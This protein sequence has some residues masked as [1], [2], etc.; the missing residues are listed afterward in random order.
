[1]RIL[2]NLVKLMLLSKGKEKKQ[3]QSKI[4]NLR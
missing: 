4:V 3:K 2:Q 1:M